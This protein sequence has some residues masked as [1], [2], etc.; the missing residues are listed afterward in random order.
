MSGSRHAENGVTAFAHLS[1]NT[2]F[3]GTEKFE[4]ELLAGINTSP[5]SL[6]AAAELG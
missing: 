3:G 2:F 1:A 6:K 4:R 5:A